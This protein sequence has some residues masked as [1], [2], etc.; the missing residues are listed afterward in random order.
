LQGAAARNPGARYE[1]DWP[2]YFDA[3]EGKPAR[4]T[5]LL[6][7]DLFEKDDPGTER[8]A[9]DLGAGSGRDTLVM[10][11]RGWSVVAID[12]SADGLD[13]LR[14]RCA[15]QRDI[16]RRLR[17]IESRF[18]DLDLDA[19]APRGALLV[20]A[21]FCLPFC[22]PAALGG[23]WSGIRRALERGASPGRPARFA[24]QFFGERDDWDAI[25][26]RSHQSRAEVES[27]LAGMAL[28]RFEEVEKDGNDIFGNPK[29]YHVFHVVARVGG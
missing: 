12:G 13:R 1:R 16:G 21:S 14:R 6:A 9:I 8:F 11:E 24:G 28:D 19:V 2:A 27:M 26:G 7:L 23:V 5:L 3:A 25:P 10:L 15:S 29:H 4:D 22:A 17:T 18:E 20:N